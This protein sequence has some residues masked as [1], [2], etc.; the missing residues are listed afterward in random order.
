MVIMNPD[1]LQ[2]IATLLSAVGVAAY[3]LSRVQ[4]MVDGVRLELSAKIDAV[5]QRIDAV[6][7][8]DRKPT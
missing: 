3:V 1:T 5:N 4:K 7:L 8:A 2:L 6:L